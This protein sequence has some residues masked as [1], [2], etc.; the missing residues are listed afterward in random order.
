MLPCEGL[1]VNVIAPA[2]TEQGAKLPVAV[3][4]FKPLR[5]FEDVLNNHVC[6]GSTE[7][8]DMMR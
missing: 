6:S 1:T 3:V 5:Q 2:G 4:S 7:V 8:R